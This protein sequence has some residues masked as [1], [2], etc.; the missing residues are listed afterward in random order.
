MC[1]IVGMIGG[2]ECAGVLLEGLKRLEYRGY[3]SAGLATVEGGELCITRA[4]GKLAALEGLLQARPMPG[5]LGVGHT[6]WATHGRPSEENAHPHRY[7]DVVVVHNGIIENYREL[8][9]ELLERG[10]EFS[11]QTDSEILAHLIQD[12]CEKGLALVEA[13][14]AA[15][16]RLE[17][18]FA[19][20]VLHRAVPD[21]FVAAKRMSPL[22]VGLGENEAF[23]ASD[24]PALLAQTRRFLF[25]EDGDVA[26]VHAGGADVRSLVTGQKLW[27]EARQVTWTPAM[28][29]KGGY[30]HFMLK[31]IHEQPRALSDTLRPRMDLHTGRVH[32]EELAPLNEAMARR[33]ERVCVVA[34]GTSYHAGLVGKTILEKLAKVPCDVEVASEFRY[35]EPLVDSRHLVVVV[36]QS[37]ETADTLAGAQE[38]KARGASVLAIC[39]AVDS[40]IARLADA[41]LYTHAGPE[42][43]VASTKAFVCQ[44][45]AFYLLAAWM[46]DCRKQVSS[47][48]AYELLRQVAEIPTDMELALL[49][50]SQIRDIARKYI[51]CR[52][53]LYLGRGLSHPIALEGALKLKELSYIHAEGFAAG[54]MKHGPIALVDEA[55]PSVFIVPQGASYEKTVSNIEEI[56]SR[57]GPVIAVAIEGDER[58]KMVADDVLFV[59][60]CTELAHPFLTILP[61]QLLAYH[62]A[63][64]KGTDVDQ[65]RNLAK[66][67]T[68][69]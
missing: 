67:V 43:G 39:N 53:M 63:D 31:E 38:A 33:I 45:G 8:K 60:R 28:A 4:P 47:A 22:I 56:R 26:W 12:E 64:L 25:L 59:P 35:R 37:G 49:Q 50:G 5:R 18:S 42:I 61:L 57:G 2:R 23:V 16:K 29:E 66:S 10:H 34:C 20:A 3:D 41:V 13:T 30:K 68:V 62:V 65:P 69:E 11:S 17:G 48:A 58:V 44:M 7:K 21:G 9:Q 51:G 54:E 27:R 36:S 55:V 19:V 14:H 1:G 15:L 46:A 24:V 32:L 40:S 6:R 52:S